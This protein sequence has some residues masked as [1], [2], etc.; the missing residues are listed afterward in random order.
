[1]ADRKVGEI[2]MDGR[3]RILCC[4]VNNTAHCSICYYTDANCKCNCNR[5]IAGKCMA[6][7]RTDKQNVV[8][9]EW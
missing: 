6:A 2:F 8:F 4:A 3:A 9:I 1:M 7:F 5:Y